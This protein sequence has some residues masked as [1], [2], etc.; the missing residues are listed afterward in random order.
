MLK[1]TFFET[2]AGMSITDAAAQAIDIANKENTDITFIYNSV[3]IKVSPNSTQQR[4]INSFFAQAA[5]R[6]DMG[7]ATQK[8]RNA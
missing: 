6:P 3:K 2:G 8:I 7:F 4:V 5:S 1:E